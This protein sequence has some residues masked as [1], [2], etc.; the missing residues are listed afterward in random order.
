MNLPFEFDNNYHNFA[1]IKVVGVGGGGGNAVNRMIEEK[2]AGVEFVVINTDAQDLEMSLAP[3]K[4]QIGEKVTRR[5]GAGA[6]PE[7][8][9]KAASEDREKIKEALTDA[10]LIF[11]TAGLGGGTGTGASP[12]VAELAKENGALTLAV[13]TKPF[14]FEGQKKM[15]YA[16][17]GIRSL[18]PSVDSLIVVPN[19][20]LVAVADDNLSLLEA[21]KM[22]DD[23][24]KQAIQGI[25]DLIA[26]PALINLDF[27][28]VKT[29][30]E[31]M[32][33]ALIGIGVASGEKRAL[34]AARQAI[35]NPLLEDVSISGASGVLINTTG[36]RNLSIKEVNEAVSLIKE[37]IDP[38]AKIIW[39]AAID[40][41][42]NDQVKVTIIAT[43]FDKKE[44]GKKTFYKAT[45]I[46]TGKVTPHFDLPTFKGKKE[47]KE[48]TPEEISPPL[49]NEK[50]LAIPTFMRISEKS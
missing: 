2:M 19:E 9:F 12:V 37:S 29:I 36:N 18:K 25:S 47:E 42:M 28:D 40:E 23:V 13:V 16:E 44:N 8:G 41:N 21:F 14:E 49:Y 48:I 22:A 46:L 38:Q 43:G 31:G 3:T 4:I 17:E 26:V 1:Q 5:L 50:E 32:G 27:A 20:K 11:I 6:D 39:G 30:T 45:K 10:D 7:L 34:E 15:E 24:L 35:S 33:T